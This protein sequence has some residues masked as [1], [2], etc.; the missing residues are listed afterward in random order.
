MNVW[1][2]GGESECKS[3]EELVSIME[4][5]YEGGVNEFLIYGEKKYPYLAVLVNNN[6]A[7]LTFFMEDDSYALQSSALDATLDHNETSIFYTG[8]PDIEIQVWNEFVVPFSK[9]L[10]AATEFFTTS[11]LPNCIE[12]SEQ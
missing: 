12:W 6:N 9:A 3:A 4:T 7:F 1:H 11:S 10:E 2:F 5:R 8:T